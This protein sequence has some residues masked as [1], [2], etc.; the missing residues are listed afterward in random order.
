MLFVPPGISGE[1]VH[2]NIRVDSH[3]FLLPGDSF[4]GDPVVE[5]D[6][7]ETIEISSLKTTVSKTRTVFPDAWLWTDEV[8]R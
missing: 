4:V 1:V 5:K 2:W 7:E 8:V 6:E 3:R